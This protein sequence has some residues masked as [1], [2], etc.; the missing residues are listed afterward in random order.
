[1]NQI[2]YIQKEKKKGSTV[3]INKIILFFSIA[4]IVFGL[5]M[6]G[7]GVYGAYKN[8][9]MREAIE[10]SAPVAS[11][12]REGQQLK[13]YASHIRAI[14]KI[15]YNW[16]N[17]EDTAMT[18]DGNGRNTITQRIDLP[19]GDNIFYLTLTDVNGKTS[20]YSKEFYMETGKDITKP[21]IELSVVGNYVKI[22]ATDETQ[23]SYITY[24]WNDEDETKVE[25]GETEN[26]KIETNVEIQRGQNTL[27]II[28]VDSSNNTTTRQEIFEGRV[29]PTLEVYID[30]GYLVITAKHEVGVKQI[31]YVL[32]GQ[33]YSI[34]Y[35]EAP[36]MTYRQALDVGYNRVSITAYSV[37]DTQETFEGECTYTP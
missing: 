26:A 20:T 19:A 28:A 17:D 22:T 32:N 29:K 25:P 30:G 4:I 14:A 15:E 31:D 18:I 16:N 10:N 6:L 13:I 23:L 1:M 7:Q 2:L 37:E 34:Q 11:I 27:T 8:A 21:K 33:A 24:R 12:D 36:E 9:E 5:V 3:E 35:P